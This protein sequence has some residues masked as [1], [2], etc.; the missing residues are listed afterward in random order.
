MS[1]MTGS[2]QIPEGRLDGRDRAEVA[3]LMNKTWAER[4]CLTNTRDLLKMIPRNDLE[5]KLRPYL[6]NIGE[7][8]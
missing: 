3:T 1:D 4:L 2:Y 8:W 6:E 7:K 5:R